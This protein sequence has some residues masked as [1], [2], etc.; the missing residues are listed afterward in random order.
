MCC[1]VSKLL[2]GRLAV[3]L[4]HGR[5]AKVTPVGHTIRGKRCV[6]AFA[7][8]SLH[9]DASNLTLATHNTNEKN[10]RRLFLDLPGPG[11]LSTPL[12]QQVGCD[13]WPAKAHRLSQCTV[14][15]CEMQTDHEVD[16][17]QQRQGE[18]C[19]VG[20]SSPDAVQ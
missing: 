2:V 16:D 6:A 11:P 20:S 4:V 18:A 3:Q 10:H 17:L 12:R 1:F 14:L 5:S 7:A 19:R 9:T 15:M 8:L 13:L